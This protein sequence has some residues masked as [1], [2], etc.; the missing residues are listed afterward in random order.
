MG[1]VLT[2]KGKYYS[3]EP[4][5]RHVFTAEEL[6]EIVEGYFEVIS[7]D[8]ITYMVVNEDGKRKGLHR[9]EQATTLL[10]ERRIQ[11]YVVGDVIVCDKSQLN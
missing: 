7:L 6:N 3:R 4:K 11:D 10:S 2:A 5:N 8:D 9:N 1:I